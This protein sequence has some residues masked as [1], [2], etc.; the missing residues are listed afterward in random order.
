MSSAAVGITSVVLC[1]VCKGSFLLAGNA[2]IGTGESGKGTGVDGLLP[3]DG[4]GVLDCKLDVLT[5]SRGAKLQLVDDSCTGR[6][7]NGLLELGAKLSTFVDLLVLVKVGTKEGSSV[8]LLCIRGGGVFGHA[9][10]VKGMKKR[11]DSDF[12]DQVEVFQEETSS[13]AM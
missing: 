2:D 8:G 10:Q 6:K 1:T 13:T 11:S 5:A 7:P 12:I 3:R 4:L 9:L